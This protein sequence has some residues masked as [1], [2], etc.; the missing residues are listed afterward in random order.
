LPWAQSSPGDELF[1]CRRRNGSGT[2]AQ[3]SIFYLRTQC[4]VNGRIMATQAELPGQ[5]FEGTSSGNVDR[6]MNALETGVAASAGPDLNPPVPAA[7]GIKRWAIGY[8]SSEK[9]SDFSGAYRFVKT[10]GRAPTLVEMHAG[11]YP[12]FGELTLQK[13]QPPNYNNVPGTDTAAAN[14]MFAVLATAFADPTNVVVLNQ[15][16]LFQHPWG[17]GG[18][19]TPPDPFA[20]PVPRTPDITFS[21]A[22]PVGTMIHRVVGGVPNSCLPPRK[23]F[24]GVT[25]I[26]VNM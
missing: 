17:N 12:N 23:G 11:N 4:D 15:L 3:N 16:A 24:P 6:C 14:S 8:Q 19:L 2:H 22:N 7:A 13:R 26:P 20:S 18:F 25:P 9:N 21:E 1:V 5:L 10:D